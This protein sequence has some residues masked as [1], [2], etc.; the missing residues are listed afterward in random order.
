M[1]SDRFN[2]VLIGSTGTLVD[3]NYGKEKEQRTD[4]TVKT[5]RELV[6][7]SFDPVYGKDTQGSPVI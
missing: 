2:C 5:S 6:E 4:V 7:R 3:G 1:V